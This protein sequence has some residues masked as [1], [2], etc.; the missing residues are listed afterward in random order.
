MDDLLEQIREIL[1]GID[2]VESSSPEGWWETSTGAEF[3][4]AKLAEVETAIRNH[5]IH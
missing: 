1:K 2:G 5:F 4:S 3:G